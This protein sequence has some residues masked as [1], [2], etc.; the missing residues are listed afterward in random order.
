MCRR[1][2]GGD[3]EEDNS[4][5]GHS[6]SDGCIRLTGKDMKELFSVISTRTTF[7]E[8]VQAFQQSKLLRGEI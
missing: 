8:I 4:S 6:E 3:L 7:V 5:I 2:Q 1:Q